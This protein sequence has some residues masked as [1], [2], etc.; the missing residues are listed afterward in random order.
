MSER[1][2]TK[3]RGKRGSECHSNERQEHRPRR[4]DRR[5]FHAWWSRKKEV[6]ESGE[7]GEQG[8]HC[9][10]KDGKFEHLGFL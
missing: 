3:W 7:D 5:D 1:G 8:L 2:I 9:V 10:E 4:E 6:C